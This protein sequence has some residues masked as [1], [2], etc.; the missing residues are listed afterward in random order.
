MSC[1]NINKYL[2]DIEDTVVHRDLSGHVLVV[3]H[4]PTGEPIS[5]EN[6]M[7]LG[8]MSVCEVYGED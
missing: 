1:E 3:L 5:L 2:Q 8:H 7:S 4:N 6:I